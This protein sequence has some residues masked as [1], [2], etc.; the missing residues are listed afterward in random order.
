MNFRSKTSNIRMIRMYLKCVENESPGRVEHQLD[1]LAEHFLEEAP[2]A[3]GDIAY[4]DVKCNN[5]AETWP[6]KQKFEFECAHEF[7]KTSLTQCAR[8]K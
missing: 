1:W 5:S 8:G 4:F 2:V 7:Q 3:N 6:Q